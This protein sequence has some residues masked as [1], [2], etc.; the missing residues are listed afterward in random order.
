MVD[1]WAFLKRQ[2][3]VREHI[4]GDAKYFSVHH[5]KLEILFAKST[6]HQFLKTTMVL[7]WGISCNTQL[8]QHN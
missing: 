8:K 4:A 6:V 1:Q 3:N 2:K 5:L 7:P